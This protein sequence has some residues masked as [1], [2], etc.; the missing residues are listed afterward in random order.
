MSEATGGGVGT[1]LKCLP[2]RFSSWSKAPMS[3]TSAVYESKIGDQSSIRSGIC[4]SI[5]RREEREVN[6]PSGKAHHPEVSSVELLQPPSER[7]EA[8][9][10]DWRVLNPR[11]ST[12]NGGIEAQEQANSSWLDRDW[13]NKSA[14][15]QRTRSYCNATGRSLSVTG[16]VGNGDS[17][18]VGQAVQLFLVKLRTKSRGLAF[19]MKEGFVEVEAAK[20]RSKACGTAKYGEKTEARGNF[21]GRIDLR[22]LLY[23][24]DRGFGTGRSAASSPSCWFVRSRDL[25]VWDVQPHSHG[26]MECRQT[27]DEK[28][29]SESSAT[30]LQIFSHFSRRTNGTRWK[31][32]E[33]LREE[34]QINCAQHTGHDEGRG[35]ILRE[36]RQGCT[37]EMILMVLLREG[38]EH[39]KRV[40]MRRPWWARLVQFG[41]I[42]DADD[43]KEKRAFFG[44]ASERLNEPTSDDSL[45]S[46][47]IFGSRRV[48]GDSTQ[49]KMSVLVRGGIQTRE[50]KNQ[51]V[52]GHVER[53]WSNMEVESKRLWWYLLGIGGNGFRAPPHP[54][55]ASNFLSLEPL[56]EPN[57]S[58]G[59]LA[60][61]CRLPPTYDSGFWRVALT[62]SWERAGILSFGATRVRMATSP[63]AASRWKSALSSSSFEPLSHGK[64]IL[65]A[66]MKYRQETNIKYMSTIKYEKVV[67]TDP[68]AFGFLRE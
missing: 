5:L 36:R 63:G 45:R 7:Q 51:K 22:K 52:S 62:K 28:K 2:S 40:S 68:E 64:L 21:A 66:P 41:S 18:R 24:R 31:P 20:I 53:T 46:S 25:K 27:S 35:L 14:L 57:W 59:A 58:L 67:E 1:V 44:Q 26:G 15:A 34:H 9:R 6:K 8:A 3:G 43:G 60:K 10:V 17:A 38:K 48:T 16:G 13:T 39:P 30:E 47:F 54:P 37:N 23:E 49:L 56:L 12:I 32:V 19:A 65:L 61:S 4:K 55:F 50:V 42:H 29:P 33:S 11:S